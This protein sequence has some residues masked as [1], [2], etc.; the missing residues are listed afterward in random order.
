MPNGSLAQ[1]SSPVLVSQIANANIPRSL[2]SASLP[3]TA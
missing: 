2:R 1:N 3:S